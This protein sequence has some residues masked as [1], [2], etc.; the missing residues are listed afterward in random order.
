MICGRCGWFLP[1]DCTCRQVADPSSMERLREAVERRHR[2]S[3]DRA[4]KTMAAVRRPPA[5][6]D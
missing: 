1:A 6:Q 2:E 4:H 3:R 5:E